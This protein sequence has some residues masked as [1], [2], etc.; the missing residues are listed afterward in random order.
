MHGCLDQVYK[1]INYK[2]AIKKDLKIISLDENLQLE[3]IT[4]DDIELIRLW[5][6]KYKNSFFYK[7][8]I[9]KEEQCGWFNIYLNI[10]DDFIFIIKYFNDI[11]GC[12]GF[13]KLKNEIDIYNVILG[14]DKYK[15]SGIMGNALILLCSFISSV[16]DYAISA[17]VLRSNSAINW[18]LKNYFE[19]LKETQEYHIIE[20]NNNFKKVQYILEG[21]SEKKTKE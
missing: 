11:V 13:R 8:D 1:R 12:L 5:K 10:N 20:L 18:Y 16:Y 3:S 17:K 9:T 7:K 21:K 2:K 4:I 6:N 19:I 15:S 14:N